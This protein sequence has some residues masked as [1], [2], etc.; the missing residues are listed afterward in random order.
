MYYVPHRKHN[1]IPGARTGKGQLAWPWPPP[2]YKDREARGSALH[3]SLCE[4]KTFNATGPNPQHLSPTWIF[5]LSRAPGRIGERSGRNQPTP[6]LG[7]GMVPS[8]RQTPPFL[9]RGPRLYNSQFRG[10]N[11]HLPPK[12]PVPSASPQ[13]GNSRAQG[14]REGWAAP[15]RSG[16]DGA[17]AACGRKMGGGPPSAAAAPPRAPAS[18]GPGSQALGQPSPHLRAK[19]SGVR[20]RRGAPA[21]RRC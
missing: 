3:T 18:P 14:Y 16:R 15:H 20:R 1:K 19:A 6:R 8:S 10:L 13:R 2:Q 9:L 7:R 12:T 17:R 4:R 21:Q 11:S 5:S